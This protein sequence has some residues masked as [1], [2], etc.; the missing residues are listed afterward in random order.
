M[1]NKHL[2]TFFGK[3][4]K[5]PGSNLDL[6][7]DCC[8]V[9][10]HVREHACNKVFLAVEGAYDE[11]TAMLGNGRRKYNVKIPGYQAFSFTR[12]TSAA[13]AKLLVC[14]ITANVACYSFIFLLEIRFVNFYLF[15]V[16]SSFLSFLLLE[17][18]EQNVN[19]V[20]RLS[21]GSLFVVMMFPPKTSVPCAR[22]RNDRNWR[23]KQSTRSS[24]PAVMSTVVEQALVLS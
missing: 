22:A 2:R 13:T 6:V 10:V 20:N 8:N 3:K 5:V 15:L 9:V 7:L 19:S 1:S 14:R 4:S 18:S 11:M 12:R 21:N 16:R 23:K 24:L 17:I